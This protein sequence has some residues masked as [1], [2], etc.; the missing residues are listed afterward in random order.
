M[1]LGLARSLYYLFVMS[2]ALHLL[3]LINYA[4]RVNLYTSQLSRN[5]FINDIKQSC[6]I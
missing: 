6:S 5:Y 3:R 2:F 1:I 4:D